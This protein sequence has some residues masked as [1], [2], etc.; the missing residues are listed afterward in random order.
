MLLSVSYTTLTKKIKNLLQFFFATFFLLRDYYFFTELEKI[1][2]I[3]N[4]NI[5]ALNDKRSSIEEANTILF[6]K[7]LSTKTKYSQV[8]LPLDL[9]MTIGGI[10]F[11][12]YI[13]F[14]PKLL[15]F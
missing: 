4:R 12:R 3:T 1:K 6:K 11:V 10:C 13:M 7:L 14:I 5:I 2:I 9:T 8:F 15:M